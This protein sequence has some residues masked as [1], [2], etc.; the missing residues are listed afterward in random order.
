MADSKSKNLL[1]LRQG[2]KET[3]KTD[4]IDLAKEKKWSLNF[5]AMEV[6]RE[7]IKKNKFK[8]KSK[9]GE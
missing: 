7:H 1:S 4:L 2:D 3:V 9:L 5:Y 8:K 6:L